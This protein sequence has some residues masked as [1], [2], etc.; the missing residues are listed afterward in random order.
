MAFKTIRE[1][2]VLFPCLGFQFFHPGR[3]HAKL[4]VLEL[5][6]NGG[7]GAVQIADNRRGNRPVAI[8]FVRVDIK[9]D[10]LAFRIPFAMPAGKQPVQARAD[11]H[12][13]VRFFHDGRTAGKRALRMIVRQE[14]L[15]HGHGEERQ[16]CC[17]DKLFY[18]VVN[19]GVGRA[20]AKQYSGPFGAGQKPD[21]P[22]NGFRR[23]NHCRARVNRLEIPGFCG[24]IIH[25]FTK[26]GF[27]DIQVNATRASR[28]GSPEGARDSNR[29]IAGLVHTEGRLD[30]GLCHIVLVQVFIAALIHVH[31]LTAAGAGNLDHGVTVDRGIDRCRQ[32]IQKSKRAYCQ[33]KARFFCQESICRG[34]HARLLLKTEADIFYA[35]LLAEI[36]KVCNRNAAQ[37][38][39]VVQAVILEGFGQYV[40]AGYLLRKV[41]S[42]A[43]RRFLCSHNI[44]RWLNILE[45]IKIF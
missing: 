30:Q 19:L 28:N 36:S 37:A 29:Q 33:Q 7:N 8:H 26:A 11:E 14:A 4:H 9:L 42:I 16:A 25:N 15:G 27:H 13:H 10:K 31:M 1:P 6:K 22:V 17:L 39:H 32:S 3:I 44:C 24:R 20:L 45:I 5:I 2:G 35:L 43:G 23:G 40:H 21:R 38:K 12:D 18:L 34:R 41:R